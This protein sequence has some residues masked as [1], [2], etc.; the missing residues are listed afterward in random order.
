MQVEEINEGAYKI[1]EVSDQQLLQVFD[2][3]CDEQEDAFKLLNLFD[4]DLI[5]GGM[6]IT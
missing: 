2:S 5:I 3:V 4:I 1:V 6:N